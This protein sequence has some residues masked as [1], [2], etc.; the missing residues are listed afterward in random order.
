MVMEPKYLGEEVIEHPNHHL[1]GSLGVHD[2]ALLVVFVLSAQDTLC[3]PNEIPVVPKAPLK[4][5]VSGGICLRHTGD[6]VLGR[7]VG[8]L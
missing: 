5:R 2:E 1:I 7:N 4:E 3:R 8:S 6:P